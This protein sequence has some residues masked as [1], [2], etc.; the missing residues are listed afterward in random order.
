MV[1]EQIIA[2]G[3]KDSAVLKALRKV[4]RER[5]I[6]KKYLDSVYGDFPLPIGAGQTISQPYMV[7]LMTQHLALSKETTVLEIGTGSGY[8]AAV[9]AELASEV[10]SVERIA[11]LAEK[12]QNTLKE[13]GY[14][15]VQVKVADGT[16]GWPEFAPYDRIMVTAS[17]PA[18]PEP[19]IKQLKL[20][21]RLVIPIGGSFNQVLTVVSKYKN[22]IETNQVCGCVFV[23]LLGKYGWREKNVE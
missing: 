12:A 15:N 16:C 23:P 5:F 19:L 9:L 1:R 11:A 6:P 8:Q 18:I 22:K 10:Y 7:A 20:K 4:P 3:I 17:T 21:A 13:L 14:H 2:R